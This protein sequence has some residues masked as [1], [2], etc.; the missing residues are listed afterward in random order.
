MLAECD[1]VDS[2]G[3]YLERLRSSSVELLAAIHIGGGGHIIAR[4]IT[5]DNA[6]CQVAFPLR[7]IVADALNLGSHAVLIAHNHP[8]GI[9]QPSKAD[10]NSTRRLNNLLWPLDIVLVD[11]LI[12]TGGKVLSMKAEGHI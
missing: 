12:V 4:R 3:D 6:P 8:S 5:S 9:A 11:H 2:L 1:P 10:L 7:T